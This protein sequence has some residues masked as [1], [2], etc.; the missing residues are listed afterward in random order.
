MATTEIHQGV[1]HSN[2]RYFVDDHAASV[3]DD[4]TWT[5][6]LTDLLGSDGQTG[7]PCVQAVVCYGAGDAGARTATYYPVINTGSALAG[8][9]VVS[10]VETTGVL[11]L[12]NRSGGAL[13][14]IRTVIQMV[15]D[16]Q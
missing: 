6:D 2:V 16:V 9:E 13:T 7:L 12:Q 4:A 10:Y 8:V 15:C 11:T 1:N 14:N 3:A 5:V